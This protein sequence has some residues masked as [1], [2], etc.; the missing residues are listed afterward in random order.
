MTVKGEVGISK[1]HPEYILLGP[2]YHL[3]MDVQKGKMSQSRP[4]VVSKKKNIKK[5]IKVNN[6]NINNSIF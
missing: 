6:I 1:L 5:H 4:T 2:C 3:M